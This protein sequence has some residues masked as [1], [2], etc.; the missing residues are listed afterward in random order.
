MKKAKIFL[1]L[2]LCV[3]VMASLVSALGLTGS[4]AESVSVTVDLSNLEA[5]GEKDVAAEAIKNA[6]AYEVNNLKLENTYAGTAHPG[7]YAGEGYLVAKLEAGAGKVFASDVVADLTYW[8]ADVVNSEVGVHGWIKL[9]VSTDNVTYTEIAKDAQGSGT[10]Y[11][12]TSR[13]NVQLPLTGTKGASVAYVKVT[14]QHWGSPYCGGIQKLIVS[15]EAEADP[16][17]GGN[18]DDQQGGEATG[19]ASLTVDLSGMSANEDKDASA[20]AIKNAG[21]MEVNNLQLEN[22]YFGFAHPS[23]YAGAGYII[24]KLEAGEGK[25]FASAPVVDLT[26]WLAVN[27][28]QGYLTVEGS[29]DNETY[30]E[31]YKDSTGAGGQYQ[32]SAQINKQITLTGAEGA[33]VAYAK[34]TVEH[35]GAPHCG[36]IQK[37]VFN[38]ATM[39]DPNAGGNDDDEDDDQQGG[40]DTPVETVDI[41][42]ELD[43]TTL[44]KASDATD[45][46]LGLG[47]IAANGLCIEDCYYPFAA[48]QGGYAPAYY[49]QTLSAGTDKVF[50]EAPVFTINYRMSTTDPLSKIKI[51]ASIDGETY[52]E[53]ATISEGLGDSYTLDCLGTKTIVLEGAEG[54]SV[55]YVKVTAERFG[56]HDAAGIDSSVIDAKVPAD[57]AG[58]DDEDEDQGEDIPTTFIT[59]TLDFSKLGKNLG[60]ASASVIAA[61]AVDA[62]GVCVED[63]YSKFLA[64]KDG[65]A[66]AYYIQKLSAGEGKT[67]VSAP[68]FTINYRMAGSSPL[69]TIKIE[70][71]IDGETYYEFATISEDLGASFTLDC[72]GSKIITLDGAEGA[73]EVYVKVTMERFGSYDSAGVESS[74][75]RAEI[76]GEPDDDKQDED[77]KSPSTGE[78]ALPIAFAA[79]ALLSAMAL[80]FVSTRKTAL[81]K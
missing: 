11:S 30:Y 66:P 38:G 4:A 41:T 77:D 45:A 35:W 80:L 31:F 28:P 76:P 10:E 75:I 53:F 68:T 62:K 2:L 9:E 32:L 18:D 63:C 36:G 8:L 21:A 19:S 81:N 39:A 51:E 43:F 34:I 67:F 58:D 74:T 12:D 24:V 33:A 72:K 29:L 65:F 47:A 48:P 1:S 57:V 23:G 61:G 54:A 46:I 6:G 15:G 55:V 49:I 20:T 79:V 69:S 13:H 70:A 56:G 50:A 17:A 25:V 73:S 27:D 71:S 44:T 42:N 37:I 59:E 22:S 78:S 7:G 5:N 64:P 60:D 14:M 16:N 40:E 52:Y 3:A 26:Y